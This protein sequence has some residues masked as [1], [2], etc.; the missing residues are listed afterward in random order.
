MGLWEPWRGQAGGGEAEA[1]APGKMMALGLGKRSRVGEEVVDSRF[2][3]KPTWGPL[4]VA[5]GSLRKG[6]RGRGGLR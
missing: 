3:Y 2:M 6:T 5:P 4:D 1:E